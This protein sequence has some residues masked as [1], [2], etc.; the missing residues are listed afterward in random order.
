MV[1]FTGFTH[2]FTRRAVGGRGGS[3]AVGLSGLVPVICLVSFGFNDAV[4][5]VADNLREKSKEC[6]WADIVFVPS[7]RPLYDHRVEGASGGVEGG[8]GNKIGEGI[9]SLGGGEHEGLN[10]A[11]NAAVN[12]VY[13]FQEFA[14]K[15]PVKLAML[16]RKPVIQEVKN[17][18]SGCVAVGVEG[19]DGSKRGDVDET[20]M[21]C[22]RVVGVAMSR[23]GGDDVVV[24]V[25]IAYRLPNRA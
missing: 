25:G 20:V 16:I 1:H 7:K 5:K 17:D 22:E 9:P 15:V 19:Y 18:E 8:I 23:V 12:L 11:G 21:E 13:K 6:V 14:C 2:E 4:K 24:G 10:L 3:A